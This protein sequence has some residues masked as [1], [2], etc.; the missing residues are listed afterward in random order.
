MSLA[1][2]NITTFYLLKLALLGPTISLSW[3]WTR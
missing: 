1:G 2:G 3:G